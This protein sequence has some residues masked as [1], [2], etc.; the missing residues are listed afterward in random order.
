MLQPFCGLA[1]GGMRC[2][3]EPEKVGTGW[4][5]D[6]RF[7]GFWICLV[8]LVGFPNLSSSESLFAGD[9]ATKKAGRALAFTW[10]GSSLAP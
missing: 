9:S 3:E 5:T 1:H 2:F 10:L 7:L 8:G 4:L 6:I